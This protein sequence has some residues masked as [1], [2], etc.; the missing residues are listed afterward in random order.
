MQRR[1]TGQHSCRSHS[2][3]SKGSKRA[4]QSKSRESTERGRWSSR[5]AKSNSP[6]GS[7]A[8]TV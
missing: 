3:W 2:P 6:A 7:K 4:L 1:E 5:P 8:G